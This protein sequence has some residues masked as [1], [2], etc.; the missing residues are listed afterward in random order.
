MATST[1]EKS[2]TKAEKVVDKV[3]RAADRHDKNPSREHD[4]ASDDYLDV[5]CVD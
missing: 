1:T 3:D 5:A 2:E 4:P